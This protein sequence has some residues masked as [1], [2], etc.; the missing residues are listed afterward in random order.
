L[1]S[2]NYE[3]YSDELQDAPIYVED[4]DEDLDEDPAPSVSE[5][6]IGDLN[7][8]FVLIMVVFKGYWNPTI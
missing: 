1:E 7:C 2:N 5:V 3:Q 6:K 8:I 4:V